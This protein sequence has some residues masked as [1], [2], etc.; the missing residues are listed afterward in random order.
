M[1]KAKSI[2][3]VNEERRKKF[4]T[5]KNTFKDFPIGTKVRVICV[6]QDMY[7]F[8]GEETGTV[9]RNSGEYLGIIIK[10]D[11]PRHYEGGY[12]QYEFNFAPDDLVAL[13]KPCKECPYANVG[14][15]TYEI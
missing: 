11:E 14:A 13:S 15:L 3:D 10:W 4:K 2:F 12:I 8:K 1:K 9:I 6:C 5:K 7:F